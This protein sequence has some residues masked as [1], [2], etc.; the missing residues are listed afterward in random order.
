MQII[1]EFILPVA[2]QQKVVMP[3]GAKIL[4]IIPK[5][6]HVSVFAKMDVDAKICHRRFNVYGTGWELS[7]VPGEYLGTVIMP[8]YV[9][10]YAGEVSSCAAWHVFDE[11][12]TPLGAH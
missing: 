10:Q 9:P 4:H 12:E 11:G 7:K 6:R 8:Q 1:Q 3:V 5:G 2:G